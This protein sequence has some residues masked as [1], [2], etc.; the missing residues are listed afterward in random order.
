MMGEVSDADRARMLAQIDQVKAT[1]REIA[2]R[3]NR[4]SASPTSNLAGGV[5]RP[6]RIVS[7]GR[8]RRAVDEVLNHIGKLLDSSREAPKVPLDGCKIRFGGHRSSSYRLPQLK[9][10]RSTDS[11]PDAGR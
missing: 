8:L 5:A 1:A 7:R 6:S 2:E 10:T 9:A 3:Y 4:E 11:R